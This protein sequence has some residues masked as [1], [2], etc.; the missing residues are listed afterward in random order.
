MA[1]MQRMMQALQAADAAGDIAAATALAQEIRRVQIAGQ[2]PGIT[3]ESLV[4]SNP[5]EYDPQSPEF[6]AR[7]GAQGT[8]AQNFAAGA[9]K[10][11][12]DLGRGIRQIGAEV[13]DRVSP[14]DR[15][16]TSLVTGQRSRADEL[17]AQQDEVN[18]RDA[19]LMRT[20]A[21]VAGNV[22]G[23]LATVIIPG[24]A[25]ARGAQV[26][27]LGRTAAAAR[28]LTNP[29]TYRAGAASG[30][31]QGALRPVGEDESRAMNTVTGAAFGGAG[32]A[33]GNT[34]G[35]VVQP[36]RNRAPNPQAVR[37]L[38]QAGVPLDTAQ[39]TGSPLMLRA[40]A[41]LSDNPATLNQQAAFIGRQQSAFNRA[42]LREIGENADAATPQV[43]DAASRRIGSY[44]DAV[45][46]RVPL[47]IDAKLGRDVQQIM[48]R[49]KSALVDSDYAALSRLMGQVQGKGSRGALTGEQYQQV[50]QAL[51]DIAAGGSLRGKL[52]QDLRSAFDGALE[53][54]AAGTSDFKLLKDARRQWQA[55]KQ[56]E[57]AVASDGT[58]M[59]SPAKL[60]NVFVQ[61]RNRYQ[62]LY[63]RGN[64]RLVR[65]AQAG[66]QV[67]TEKTPNSGT[68]ARIAAQLAPSALVGGGYA[69]ATGDIDT[70]AKIGAATYLIPRAGQALL[71]NRLASQYMTQGL[72]QGATRNLL[73]Q[74]SGSAITRQLPTAVAAR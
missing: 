11:V 29:A 15:G 58:G 28:A 54:S 8:T 60:A 52:A 63:G 18:A 59:I 61:K 21:G 72:P 41:A 70:A 50:K 74:I 62:G 37:T 44:F 56:I 46:Q 2:N 14:R 69:L 24:G 13:M 19:D 9:G 16:I 38:E 73:Q 65:L 17:R 40:R 6:R 10:A 71:T 4:A 20:G 26:A 57:Q 23:N 67:L 25:V 49:G 51:D 68:P 48:Q 30:A 36:L 7:Y 31:I 42:A 5:A 12:V 66:K 27:K 1:D 3:R 32:V 55:L 47:R 34:L 35:R 22:A 43:L 53:R 39:R 45:S 64:Q 33:L